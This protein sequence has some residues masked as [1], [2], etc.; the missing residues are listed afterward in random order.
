VSKFAPD[1]IVLQIEVMRLNPRAGSSRYRF[2]KV[3]I[4]L[5]QQKLMF[6]NFRSPFVTTIF[7]AKLLSAHSRF[8]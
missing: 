2:Q 8:S 3:I 1:L 7:D 4:T 5:L 6:G